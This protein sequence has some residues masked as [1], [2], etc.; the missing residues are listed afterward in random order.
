[1]RGPA[2]CLET[3]PGVNPRPEMPK[4][5]YG[6]KVEVSRL[7]PRRERGAQGRVIDDGEKLWQPGRIFIEPGLGDTYI[8]LLYNAPARREKNDGS[9]IDKL[10][11]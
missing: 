11:E 1:M 2:R 5:E 8:L 3:P 6:R 10:E 7:I 4:F 9:M